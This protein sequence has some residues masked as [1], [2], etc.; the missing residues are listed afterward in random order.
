[1][2]IPVSRRALG[3]GLLGA[4]LFAAMPMTAAAQEYPN[5][6]IRLI[7]PFTGG[8]ADILARSFAQRAR[9]GQPI[10]VENVPGASGAIGYTRTARSAADGYTITIGMTGTF[11]V[12]PNFNPQ[13]GYHPT[14]DFTPIAMTARLPIVLVANASAP[15]KTVPELIAYAKAN[16]NKLNYAS[17]SPGTT[18]HV[19]GEMLKQATGTDIVHV[20]YKGG[21]PALLAVLSGEVQLLFAS[22]IEAMPQITSGQLRALGIAGARRVPTLPDVPTM[23]EQGLSFD[24]PIW[25]G[26]FAPAGT[27]PEIIRKLSDEALRIGAEDEMKKFLAER[28]AEPGD[29]GAQAFSTVVEQEYAK[30]GRVIRSAGLKAE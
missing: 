2:R 27:P 7:V 10:V 14:K 6:P 22:L 9:L 12:S 4:A 28:G 23:Q 1:M 21:S 20:P 30:Y 26:L 18:S 3:L 24:T 29:V 16:P 5:R 11:A 17:V 15:F 13:I 19:L 25:Y 8:T